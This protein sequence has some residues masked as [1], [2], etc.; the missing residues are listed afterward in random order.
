MQVNPNIFKA[1]DIRDVYGA[2]LDE[3][4]AYQIG[5][6]FAAYLKSSPIVVGY[7]TRLSSLALKTALIKGLTDQGADVIDIG[8]CSTPCFY[9]TAGEPKS[10]GGIMVT[11]SHASKEFNGFKPVF[12]N[13]TALS[14]EQILELKEIIL[15][16]KFPS[17]A[18]KGSVTNYDPADD[19]I[20]TVKNSIKGKFKP[21]KIV[22]D[23]GNGMAGLYIEKIFSGTN[24]NIIPIYTELNGD[25][26]NH[27]TNPKISENRKKL[28][29]KVIAEK[30]D[31]GFMF[32]GDADRLSIVDRQGRLFDYSLMLALIAEFRVKNF[33]RKKVII[34]VRTSDIVRDWVEKAGGQVEVSVCWTIPIKLKMQADPEIIFGGETSG[35]C[36]FPELHAADDGLFGALTF[37]QA[38]SAK[39]ETIDE[40]IEKFREKYFVLDETNFKMDNMNKANKILKKVKAECL[41][42]GAKIKEID[43]ISVIFPG[44]WFNLRASET[45]PYIRLNLEASS[46]ELFE[47]KSAEIINLIN[48]L[49]N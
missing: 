35:H 30:A 27:E 48:S 21:L 43:G 28:I 15:K 19:Y 46:K 42:Q 3:E 49:A 31:L 39:P 24:L 41:A 11:A 8:L 4:I 6:G 12:K 38:V 9:F 16:N 23:A 33:N 17:A 45:E 7:D 5:R 1:Y 26:P 22:M 34:E 2:D 40:I 47:A 29:K 14:R 10:G 37:L 13:N 44:W 25:F 32:D 18:K 36:I 20:Q